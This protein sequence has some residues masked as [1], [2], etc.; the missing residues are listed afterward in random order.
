V[1]STTLGAEGLGARDGESLLLATAG[2]HSRRPVSQLLA[3]FELR[4]RVG[5]AGRLLLEKE[6][7]WETA[8]KKLDF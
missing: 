7:T 3:C 6:F 4:Q 8:W 1:V 5:A 2:R